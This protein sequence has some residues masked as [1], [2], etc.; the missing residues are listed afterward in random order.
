MSMSTI[1][2]VAGSLC[3]VCG[4]G[5]RMRNGTLEQKQ[6]A[7]DVIALGISMI[8]IGYIFQGSA[9]VNNQKNLFGS[10]GPFENVLGKVLP[11]T[12]DPLVQTCSLNANGEISCL[13]GNINGCVLE[14]IPEKKIHCEMGLKILKDLHIPEGSN[15]HKLIQNLVKSRGSLSCDTFLPWKDSFFAPMSRSIEKIA[16]SDMRLT[17][18]WGMDPFKRFFFAYKGFSRELGHEIIV[19]QQGCPMNFNGFYSF[20]E[21]VEFD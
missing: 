21:L 7:M 20:G 10:F 5:Q 1:S 6:R 12:V 18:M 4:V 9:P 11:G 2:M 17:E 15:L 14:K 19:V 3:V 8:A 13:S 16:F